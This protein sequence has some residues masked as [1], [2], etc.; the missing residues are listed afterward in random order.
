MRIPTNE[1]KLLNCA[2]D[3]ETKQ[4]I[5]DTY[6]VFC[7]KRL[8]QKLWTLEWWPTQWNSLKE[9][10]KSGSVRRSDTP[11]TEIKVRWLHR[12]TTW[13]TP[14]DSTQT[15]YQPRPRFPTSCRH[16]NSR[17][18]IKETRQSSDRSSTCRPTSAFLVTRFPNNLTRQAR[19]EWSANDLLS[20]EIPWPW[21]AT[22]SGDRCWET[23]NRWVTTRL[24]TSIRTRQSEGSCPVK[25]LFLANRVKIIFSASGSHSRSPFLLQSCIFRD[26]MVRGGNRHL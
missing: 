18:W 16:N 15:L 9:P 4:S 14:R 12:R 13:I 2:I 7:R 20:K 10:S 25:P 19:A 8:V 17:R 6:N 11:A 26:P 1:F 3:S 5:I 23:T 21:I 24:G 22:A